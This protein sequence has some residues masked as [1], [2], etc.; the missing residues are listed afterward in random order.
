MGFSGYQLINKTNDD[1]LVSLMKRLA[2]H[3]DK[4]AL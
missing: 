3:G 2:V 4:E 1:I